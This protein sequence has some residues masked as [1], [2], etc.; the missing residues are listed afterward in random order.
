MAHVAGTGTD[1][2]EVGEAREPTSLNEAGP[3]GLHLAQSHVGFLGITGTDRVHNDGDLTVTLKQ[4]KGR[5]LDLTFRGRPDQDELTGLHLG[6]QPVDPGLIK[7]VQA[8]LVEDDL[9][10]LA[11]QLPGQVGI[12]VG[13]QADPIGQQGVGDLARAVRSSMSVA[14]GMDLTGRNDRNIVQSGPGHHPPNVGQDPTVIPNAA[15]PI[16][17]EEVP[18][19]IDVQQDLL[20]PGPDYLNQHG[21]SGL[22]FP[23]IIA[24][25]NP[26]D[27]RQ[28]THP[29]ERLPKGL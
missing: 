29:I 8:S 20:S 6:Q 26:A 13:D 2:T 22:P 19:G 28:C 17:Q 24:A 3:L 18:L 11:E 15:M 1:D 16:G 25:S 21:D 5:G 12:A 9:S 10:V 23:G 27:P 4:P 7:G 14:V